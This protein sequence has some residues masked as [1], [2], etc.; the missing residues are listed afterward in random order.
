MEFQINRAY[1]KPLFH[2]LLKIGNLYQGRSIFFDCGL[3][4]A[5]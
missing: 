2:M 1:F 4:N 5:Y 3:R